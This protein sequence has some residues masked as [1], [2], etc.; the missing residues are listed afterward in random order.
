VENGLSTASPSFFTVIDAER[1]PEGRLQKG[2]YLQSRKRRSLKVHCRLKV[3]QT[4]DRLPYR[5]RWLNDDVKL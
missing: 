1:K 3:T 4:K 5:L 2:E